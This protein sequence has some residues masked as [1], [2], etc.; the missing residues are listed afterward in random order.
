[1]NTP[2]PYCLSGKRIFMLSLLLCLSCVAKKASPPEGWIDPVSGVEFVRITKG[3]FNM[4][5]SGAVADSLIAA[6]LHPVE[7][8]ADFWMGRTEITRKQWERLMGSE[9]LHPDKPNPFRKDDPDYP[10]VSVSFQDVERYLEV[11]NNREGAW[12]FRLPTEAE[13][14]YACRAGTGTEFAF[15]DR[16]TDSL[17]NY[18][19][20]LPSHLSRP[21]R[22][23]GHPAPVG[24]YPPNPWGLYDM[25][26]NAWEWVS[27][28]YAPYTDLSVD[29]KGPDHGNEKVLRGG[30]WFFGAENARSASRRTHAPGLWGF[31]IGFRVV[32]EPR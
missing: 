15:G 19:A 2:V 6:P 7:L 24:S 10:M 21:G 4:G 1:M 26:G 23:V 29:P 25:H 28:W 9:E 18:R 11:L 20:D 14:E 32:A 31:S 30:S 13:W 8:T 17:A 3:S 12:H 22:A 5:G 27:D 16:L